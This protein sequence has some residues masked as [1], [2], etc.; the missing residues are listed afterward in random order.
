MIV[1]ILMACLLPL[2]VKAQI[3]DPDEGDIPNEIKLQTREDFLGYYG[4]NDSNRKLIELFFKKRALD[5]GISFVG[6][7][8]VGWGMG[9]MI[10]IT[11]REGQITG[12]VFL[13]N[14]SPFLFTGIVLLLPG[15]IS[16][17]IYTRAVLIDYLEGNKPIPPKIRRKR[18]RIK[19]PPQFKI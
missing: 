15:A 19:L 5:T 18:D 4:D 17:S 7:F 8:S 3:P 11:V 6:G 14:V 12:Q 2:A 1:A 10:A 13:R 16:G 9:T